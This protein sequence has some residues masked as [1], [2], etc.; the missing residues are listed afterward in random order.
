MGQRILAEVEQSQRRRPAPPDAG[1]DEHHEGQPEVG[2]GQPE[3]G[4]AAARVIAQG[5][6]THRRVDAHRQRDQQ[7]DEQRGAPQL[8][9]DGYSGENLPLH[10]SVAPEQRLTEGAFQQNPSHPPHVS[11]VRGDIETHDNAQPILLLGADGE[12]GVGRYDV[13]DVAWNRTH[14]KEHQHA[15]DEQRGDE[16]QQPADDVGSHGE[17]TP[18]AAQA[19]P[20]RKRPKTS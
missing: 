10:G 15:Q 8:Q 9:A 14:R 17:R 13:D 18:G 19:D 20:R 12:M 6:L 1:K 3:D 5:V 2:R 11:D 7:A 4:D 16:Q